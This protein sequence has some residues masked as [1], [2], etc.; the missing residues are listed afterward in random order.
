MYLLGHGQPSQ[1]RG[2]GAPSTHPLG[3]V[4]ENAPSMLPPSPCTEFSL[5]FYSTM[6]FYIGPSSHLGLTESGPQ[7]LRYLWHY[8]L[9][10]LPVCCCVGGWHSTSGPYQNPIRRSPTRPNRHSALSSSLPICAHSSGWS[11]QRCLLPFHDQ[12]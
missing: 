9:R 11:S 12:G 6:Y 3:N 1:L 7:V 2:P 4:H 5:L 8:I 10:V